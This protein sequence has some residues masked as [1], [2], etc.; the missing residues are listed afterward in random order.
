MDNKNHSG[1]LSCIGFNLLQ[2]IT[3]NLEKLERFKGRKPNEVQASRHENGYAISAILLTIVLLESSIGRTQEIINKGK[4]RRKIIALDFVKKHY[5]RYYRSIEEL[6]VLRDAIVHNHLWD[7]TIEIDLNSG[8]LRLLSANLISGYGDKKFSRVI[9]INT[10]RTKHLSLNLFPT[11]INRSDTIK[12]LRWV[13]KF[14]LFLEKNNTN[15][16]YLSPQSVKY[17]GKYVNFVKIIEQL[18]IT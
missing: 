15:Y 5:K 1:Y 8:Q 4:N 6:Y 11:R 14:L 10:R 18:K 3:D 16:V 12:T 13:C 7:S 2:P 17:H 9:N